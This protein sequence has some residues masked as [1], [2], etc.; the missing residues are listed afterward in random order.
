MTA[1]AAL[2]ALMLGSGIWGINVYGAEFLTDAVLEDIEETVEDGDGIFSDGS[3]GD[4][5]GENGGNHGSDE[6]SN[7][8]NS[9]NGDGSVVDNTGGGGSAGAVYYGGG[10]GGG[11][12]SSTERIVRQPKLM[13]ESCSLAEIDLQAGGEY[14]F[15]AV[16][17]NKS[18]KERIYNL[19]AVVTSESAEVSFGKKSFY[20]GSVAAGGSLS[21]DSKLK[22]A[23]DAAE[24]RVPVTVSFEYEDKKGTT[25]TG[26]ES[27][28]LRVSQPSE[29]R[30]ECGDLPG[31]AA[32]TDTLILTVKAQNL[33]RTPVRNV[34]IALAGKGLFPK[35][36]VF[37]GNMEAGTQGEGVMRVYVGTRTM[38]KIGNDEGTSDAEMYG[39]TKGKLT[40]IYEDS[41]GNTHKEAKKFSLEITKPKIMTLKVEKP[42]EANSW[43]FSVIAVAGVGMLAVIL[44]LLGRLRRQRIRIEEMKKML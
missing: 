32:S 1:G 22:I 12:G 35:E 42:K 9:G 34:R 36:E 27:L 13:L 6:G 14:A 7:G 41:A 10:S 40:L 5:S 18:K 17:S 21:L 28:E 33:S 11:S 39:A 20:F 24:G 38:K 44:L 31:T 3:E 37:I 15:E 19:K 16:F 2:T 26:A 25:Y 29:V 8:D 23:P 43:W 30:F 4:L